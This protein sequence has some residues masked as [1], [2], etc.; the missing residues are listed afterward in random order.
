MTD[1]QLLDHV[2]MMIQQDQLDL[3]EE[4]EDKYLDYPNY[5][6]YPEWILDSED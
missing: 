2:N 1:R 3:I 5:S 6:E 4:Y